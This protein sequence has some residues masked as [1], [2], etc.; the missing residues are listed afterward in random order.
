MNFI[1]VVRK[2]MPGHIL[3]YT[4]SLLLGI[5]AQAVVLLQPQLSGA[6]IDGVQQHKAIVLIAVQLGILFI[7]GAV[8]RAIGTKRVVYV[9]GLALW[10]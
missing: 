8:L 9:G 3:A 6:L 2:Y 5:L 4:A 10:L 1:H 7:L